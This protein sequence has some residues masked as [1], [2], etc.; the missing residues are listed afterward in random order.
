MELCQIFNLTIHIYNYKDFPGF[1]ENFHPGVKLWIAWNIQLLFKIYTRICGINIDN[2]N[3]CNK[4]REP[5]LNLFGVCGSFTG[6]KYCPLY[7]P[8]TASLRF[9][10]VP[11][12]T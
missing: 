8:V 7:F 1:R 12:C 4:M 5:M 6:G 9:Q 10:P 3:V 2:R 11:Y